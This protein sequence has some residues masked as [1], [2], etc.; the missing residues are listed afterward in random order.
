MADYFIKE[1]FQS[2]SD[3]IQQVQLHEPDLFAPTELEDWGAVY[4]VM[5]QGNQELTPAEKDFA[6]DVGLSVICTWNKYADEIP[7]LKPSLVHIAQTLDSL[8]NQP[9]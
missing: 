2:V 9:T 6:I 1:R 3:V 8:L 7:A 5:Q 4:Y